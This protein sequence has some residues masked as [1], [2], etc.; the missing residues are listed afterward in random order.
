MDHLQIQGHLDGDGLRI[1]TCSMVTGSH[2]VKTMP[3]VLLNYSQLL[4]V[5]FVERPLRISAW[6]HALCNHTVPI[7]PSPRYGD[8]SSREL[9]RCSGEH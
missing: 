8:R 5:V 4:E 2:L 1:L 7:G 3:Y 9:Q 6:E